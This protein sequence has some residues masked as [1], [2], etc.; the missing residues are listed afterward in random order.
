MLDWPRWTT[1][2]G[3]AE[4]KPHADVWG[5]TREMLLALHNKAVLVTHEQQVTHTCN[6]HWC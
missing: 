5:G 3:G 2:G 1:G 4:L 6:A